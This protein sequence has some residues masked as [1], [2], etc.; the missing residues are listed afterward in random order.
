MN[1][2]VLVQSYETYGGHPSISITGD[3]LEHAAGGRGSAQTLERS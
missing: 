1:A 3:L 2:S